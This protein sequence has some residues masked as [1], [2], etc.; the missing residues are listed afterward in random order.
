VKECVALGGNICQWLYSVT[1]PE[2]VFNARVG[3][4]SDSAPEMFQE[5]STIA[6]VVGFDDPQATLK[7]SQDHRSPP[8]DSK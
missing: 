4:L 7:S 6:A 2:H 1:I 8:Y 3:Q 5:P